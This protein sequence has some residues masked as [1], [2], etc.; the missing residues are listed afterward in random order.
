MSEDHDWFQL[1][2]KAGRM[3]WSNLKGRDIADLIR[4][5]NPGLPEEEV[6]NRAWELW[7]FLTNDKSKEDHENWEWQKAI[8]LDALEDEQGDKGVLS[9][10]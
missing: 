6:Q 3:P 8:S 10:G 5:E 9:H 4:Y 2:H 7:K 1:S